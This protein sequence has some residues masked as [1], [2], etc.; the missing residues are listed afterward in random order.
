VQ[1][2]FAW[3]DKYYPSGDKFDG[4]N[5][6]AFV[7]GQLVVDVLKR[8]GDLLTRENVMRQA[9][10]FHEF[11]AAMIQPGITVNTSPDDYNMFKKLQLLVFDGQHLSPV[12]APIGN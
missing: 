1:R 11:K 7:E 8:C 5:A 4:L 6:A 9:A 10:S 12:G 3:M 2:Y